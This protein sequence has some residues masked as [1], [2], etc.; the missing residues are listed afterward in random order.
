MYQLSIKLENVRRNV[1]LEK[2]IYFGNIFKTKAE[3]EEKLEELQKV[4]GESLTMKNMI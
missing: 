2:K 1:Q 3:V 4:T